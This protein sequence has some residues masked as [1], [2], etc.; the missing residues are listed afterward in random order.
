MGIFSHDFLVN[1]FLYIKR[2]LKSFKK[3]KLLLGRKGEVM[4]HGSIFFK[5]IITWNFIKA[6][7]THIILVFILQSKQFKTFNTYFQKFPSF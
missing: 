1:Y 7:N 4:E 6:K 5:K 2:K 3:L